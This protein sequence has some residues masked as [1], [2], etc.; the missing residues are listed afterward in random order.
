MLHTGIS[1][2]QLPLEL[3]FGSGP[4]RWRRLERWQNAGVIVQLHHIGRRTGLELRVRG[5][6][7]HARE[8]GGA[9]K[10]PSPVDCCKTD[11]KHRLISVGNGIPL[12][13]VTTAAHINDV[14]Q[15][16]ELVNGFPWVAD[17]VGHPR[18]R[19]EALLCDKGYDS[20]PVCRGL[21]HRG[22]LPVFSRRG[23][24]DR[25]GLGK[26]RYVVK[27]IFALLP[28]CKR[29]ADRWNVVSTFTTP[30]SYGAAHSS[31]G[32]DFEKAIT[33]TVVEYCRLILCNCHFRRR[34]HHCSQVGEILRG[35]AS[36]PHAAAPWRFR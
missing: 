26:L 32:D 28:Q 3:G 16:M 9:A 30:S 1:W 25:H 13:V 19:P 35:Y 8:K 14:T 5:R 22:I 36:I 4:T 27:Q 15:T 2:Q 11:S 7:P 29:L 20:E 34:E 23:A 6:L 24:P 17:R 21:R 18:K 33:G 31:A 12:K 10:G